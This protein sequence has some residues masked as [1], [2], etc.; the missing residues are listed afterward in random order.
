[1]FFRGQ[2]E[3]MAITALQKQLIDFEGSWWTYDAPKDQVVADQF[4]L[5]MPEYVEQLN[6]AVEADGAIEYNQLVVRRLRRLRNR[7]MRQRF[8][9]IADGQ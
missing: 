2:S 9:Q 4:S 1:M 5:T 3:L 6:E 8:E 7:R